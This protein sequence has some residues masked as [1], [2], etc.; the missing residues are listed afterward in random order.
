MFKGAL[1]LISIAHSRRRAI[2]GRGVRRC[3]D[4]DENVQMHTLPQRYRA[5]S[6]V[7]ALQTWHAAKAH[8]SA[9]IA[10]LSGYSSVVSERS[11]YVYATN[12][13]ARGRAV[14]PAQSDV[15]MSCRAG[16]IADAARRSCA[17]T[18]FTHHPTPFSAQEGTLTTSQR[19]WGALFAFRYRRRG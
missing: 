5:S 4:V 19:G 10:V 14:G 17:S 12:A 8:S 7:S 11:Y 1:E 13:R 6:I 2:A 3:R 16:G 18:N 9:C 15:L